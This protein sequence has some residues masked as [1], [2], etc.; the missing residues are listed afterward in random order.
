VHEYQYYGGIH[1]FIFIVLPSSAMKVEAVCSRTLLLT[2][3]RKVED[4]N[5]NLIL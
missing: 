5:M 2:W 3:C 1:A 4:D